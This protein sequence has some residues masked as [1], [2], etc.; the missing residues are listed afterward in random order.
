MV[1]L[2]GTGN[3]LYLDFPGEGDFSTCVTAKY[4]NPN[5]GSICDQEGPECITVD[6]NTFK[7]DRSFTKNLYN[8][9]F[10]LIFMV[11][12]YLMMELIGQI[13][14]DASCCKYDSVVDFHHL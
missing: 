1:I 2:S 12:K 11:R 13:F 3:E 5:S 10:P 4:W 8:T 7:I 9:P 14:H 6:S